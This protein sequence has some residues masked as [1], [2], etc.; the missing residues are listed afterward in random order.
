MLAAARRL[1]LSPV[2]TNAVVMA[3]PEDWSLHRLLRAI[4][5]NTTISALERRTGAPAHRRSHRRLTPDE[6]LAPLPSPPTSTRLFPDCPEAVRATEEIAERCRYRIP[7]GRVVAP[8]LTDVDDALQQL[9][10][11]AYEGAQR[12]Y[13]TDRAGDP[14]PAGARA[15]HHR[16]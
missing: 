14:R 9:R 2:A 15:R 13:G 6:R 10:A 3:H 5:L 4:H 11:L 8:R 1:G 7:L 16:A 12:R